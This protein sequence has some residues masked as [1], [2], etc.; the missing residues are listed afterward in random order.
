M[1]VAAP[2]E[3]NWLDA[4]Q[5]AIPDAATSGIVE[6]FNYGRGRQG[7]IPLSVGEGDVPAPNFISEAAA[8]SADPS[9]IPLSAFWRG[10]FLRC[11]RHRKQ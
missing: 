5:P 1:N 9:R 10:E 3:R 11:L 4:I 6:V 2:P 8:A 7:L